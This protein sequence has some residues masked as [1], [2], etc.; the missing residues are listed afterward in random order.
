MCLAPNTPSILSMG[1]TLTCSY[2]YPTKTSHFSN[3]CYYY[4]M[5]MGLHL[6]YLPHAITHMHVHLNP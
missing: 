6:S 1:T 5:V 2:K 3:Y 4:N